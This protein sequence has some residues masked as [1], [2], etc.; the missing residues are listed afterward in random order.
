MDKKNNNQKN[1]NTLENESVQNDAISSAMREYFEQVAKT[2]YVDP[3]SAEKVVHEAFK[4]F[5]IYYDGMDKKKEVPV[6][7][8]KK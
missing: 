5:G 6:K 2:G 3:K 4:S 8:R 1:S 7:K